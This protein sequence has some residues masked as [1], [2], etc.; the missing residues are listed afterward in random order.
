MSKHDVIIVGGGI[1]GLACA[2][3]LHAAGRRPLV[4]EGE[5]EVGGRIRTDDVDGFLLDRGFQVLLTA[6]PEA[7]AVLD[8]EALDLRTFEPGSL[9][10]S[11]GRFHRAMDPIRQPLMAMTGAFSPIGSFGDKLRVLK[12]RQRLAGMSMEEIFAEPDRKA[13]DELRDQ[14]FS[15]TMIDR[16]FR[17]F[18]G[19]I[20]L[21]PSL[22]TSARMLAFVFKMFAEGDA[23]V[24]NLGMQRIPEQL[25]AGLPAGSVRTGAFVTTVEPDRVRTE[26]GE[27]LE[28][29]AVVIATGISQAAKL[30]KHVKDRP[31]NATAN[32]YFEA[33]KS[34]VGEPI[35]VLGG[36]TGGIVNNLCVPSDVAPGYAPTGRSLVSV[37]TTGVSTSSENELIN[38]V[39]D[40]MREWYGTQVD[41]WRHLRTYRIERALPSQPPSVLDPPQRDH[42]LADGT[43]IT[44]DHRTQASTQGALVSGRLAAQAILDRAQAD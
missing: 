21:E 1:A 39:L 40:E 13:L 22:D 3:H 29:G 9:I 15:D 41:E 11:G 24:P 38:L 12:Y 32:L 2:R 23:A 25:A 26:E 14:G 42:L 10:R 43:Y 16:F 17:P 36:D 20:F 44:G 18:L 34:P 7:R 33:P 6:Y 35:L 5:D 4:L 30:S 28:A 27:V 19:G 31:W 8:Y 37:S